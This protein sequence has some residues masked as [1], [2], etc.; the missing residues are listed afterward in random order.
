MKLH[1]GVLP[2]E[3]SPRKQSIRTASQ[4]CPRGFMEKHSQAEFPKEVYPGSFVKYPRGAHEASWKKH[5]GTYAPLE[6]LPREA[7]LNGASQSSSRLL[8]YTL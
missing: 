1:L 4:T 6:D 5:Q 2:W 8:L 3:A 7:P